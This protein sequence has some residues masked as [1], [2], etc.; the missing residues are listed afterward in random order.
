MPEEPREVLSR[1]VLETIAS[2]SERIIEDH[3]RKLE[4]SAE[5]HHPETGLWRRVRAWG[6]LARRRSA[7]VLV[8]TLEDPPKRS[9]KSRAPPWGL[10]VGPAPAEKQ[11]GERD[12]QQ[13]I[14]K[15]RGSG[16]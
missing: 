13:R 16:C 3:E 10:P 14:G 4:A 8:L 2:L 5:E 9:R 7:G 6:R 1:P 15:R 11:S 12:P